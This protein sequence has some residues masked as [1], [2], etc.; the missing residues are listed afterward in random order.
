MEFLIGKQ[1]PTTNLHHGSSDEEVEQWRKRGA[2][3]KL[4]NIVVYI[5]R[6]PQRLRAFTILSDGLRV[7]R[8]NDTRW[9]SWYRMVDWALKPKV[10]QAVTIVCMQ[11]SPFSIGCPG[12]FRLG[13]VG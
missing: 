11:E 2:I 8:D 10:R 9:N 5:T 12:A 4:H 7:R 1:P 13:Y 6:S 3:G